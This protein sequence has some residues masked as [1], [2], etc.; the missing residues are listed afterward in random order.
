M[1][2]SLLDRMDEK[3][4]LIRVLQAGQDY[5]NASKNYT[6]RD[7]VFALIACAVLFVCL[8]VFGVLVNISYTQGLITEFSYT[9]NILIHFLSFLIQVSIVLVM[10][11]LRKQKVSSFGLN[12]NAA[13]I[14]SM[15]LAV[16][17]GLVATLLFFPRIGGSVLM[18]GGTFLIML[19]ILQLLFSSFSEELFFRAYVGPRLYGVMRSKVLSIL[20]TGWLFGLAHV[21]GLFSVVFTAGFTPDVSIG[22]LPLI[23]ASISHI[24]F[25]VVCHWLYAKHNNIWGATLFHAYWNFMIVY[26][27]L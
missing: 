17:A 10:L 24:P 2:K 18:H 8:N 23:L 20:L 11:K 12:F 13:A 16:A 1:R 21:V 14:K 26:L 15:G 7:A 25:H 4:A 9:W 6:K 22:I 5:V 19:R 27:I 3:N